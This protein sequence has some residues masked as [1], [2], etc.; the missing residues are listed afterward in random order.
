MQRRNLLILGGAAVAAGIG[1]A[2]LSA[3]DASSSLILNEPSGASGAIAS[4]PATRN[5]SLLRFVATADTGSSN[6]NQY[7]VAAAMTRCY[8]QN[9]Y[10]LVV[11]AGDNIYDNGE[12]GKISSAFEQPYQTLLKNGVIFRACLGN[13]DIRSA[14]GDRQVQYPGFNMPGRYYTFRDKAV[15]FFVLDTNVNVDWSAQ[16]PWLE[17]ELSRSNALWKIVYGHHPIYSSGVY[18]N[19]QAFIDS[20]SPLF[21]KYG[22]QLYINGH[23][24]SYERTRP[25]NGT[26]YLITGNG[27]AYLRAVG[28]S[29]WTEYS[30]SRYGFTAFEVFS[31][32]INVQAIATDHQVFDRG[33]IPLKAA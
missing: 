14:N 31:D 27:G 3:M 33:T 15:Q 9:P 19:T 12:I 26:T 13:H 2:A 32:R 23:E 16:R 20:L 11:L 5:Q 22:V 18:G 30:V 1:K 24:H 25:I 8:Q 6:E 7:A 29:P 17:K 4:V 28:R 10:K 21:K